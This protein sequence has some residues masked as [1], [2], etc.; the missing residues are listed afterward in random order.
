MLH[1]LFHS[2]SIQ[3]KTIEYP[4][5][6]MLFIAFNAAWGRALH[7]AAYFVLFENWKFS[8]KNR[9]DCWFIFRFTNF[10]FVS[11]SLHHANIIKQP[12]TCVR[13]DLSCLN[14]LLIWAIH[15]AHM[16]C[17]ADAM[18]KEAHRDEGECEISEMFKCEIE[19]L[20]RVKHSQTTHLF[21]EWAILLNEDVFH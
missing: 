10:E 6:M 11:S 17:T 5:L 18:T 2:I 9:N 1:V 3:L 8:S 7:L 14:F 20:S 15:S 12:S 16:L 13:N 21:N 4:S 19:N